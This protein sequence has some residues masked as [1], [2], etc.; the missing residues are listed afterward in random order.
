[1]SSETIFLEPGDVV[2][3]DGVELSYEE[4]MKSKIDSVI[5]RKHLKELMDKAK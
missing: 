5:Y 3:V 2:N 4:I 1:M